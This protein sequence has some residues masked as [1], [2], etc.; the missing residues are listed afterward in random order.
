MEHPEPYSDTDPRAMAVW[1]GLLRRMS[2]AEKIA[3]VFN[4]TRIAFE[5]SEAGVRMSYPKAD[6]R[7]VFLRAA[8]RRLSPDLMLRAYGWDPHSNAGSGG[9][10]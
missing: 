10:L 3:A 7:E 4:L 1:I 6:N 2:P 9:G 5:L 8:A